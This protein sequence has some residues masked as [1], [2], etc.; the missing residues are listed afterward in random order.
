M[1]HDGP[2]WDDL[3][4]DLHLNQLDDEQRAQVSAELERDAALRARSERLGRI[5]QPL[6]SWTLPP[7]PANLADRILSGA[8]TSTGGSGNISFTRAH[9]GGSA[10]RGSFRWSDLLA[11][12]ACILLL[13]TVFFPGL[14]NLRSNARRQICAANL[15]SVFQ[16]LASYQETFGGSLPAAPQM[17]GASWLRGGASGV[18]YAS[19]SRHVF[20]VL[21][22]HHIARP[23]AFVCPS[24]SSGNPMRAEITDELVDFKRPANISYDALNMAGP[25]PQARQA[26]SV[27]YMSDR[28]PLFVEGRFHEN[29]DPYGTNSPV[30]TGGSGQNVMTLDG[31]VSWTSLPTYGSHR[32]NL[33]TAEGIRFYTGTEVQQDADDAFLVPSLPDEAGK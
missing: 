26:A 6:D 1:N 12:A 13:L 29:V 11:A 2:N 4:L 16:G 33:W 14:A 28:N 5:L 23:E 9:Q 17:P 18:P 32:D 21:R 25:V 30:H 19:N 15:G 27:A 20:L 10:Y 31:A 3:L 7:P 24:D 8:R 22:L